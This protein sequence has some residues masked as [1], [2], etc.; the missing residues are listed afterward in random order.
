MRQLVLVIAAVRTNW[1]R[2][3]SIVGSGLGLL[4][5]LLLATSARAQGAAPAPV[6]A[7]AMVSG[8]TNAG[9]A[10]LLPGDIVRLRIWREPDLS[11]DFPVDEKGTVVFPKIGPTQVL[12]MTTDSLKQVLVTTYAQYLRDP[13][14]EVTFLRRVTILGAVKNPGLYPVDPTMTVSDAVALAGGALPTGRPHNFEL[15]RN[16]QRIDVDFNLT[17]PIGH[18]PIRSG[19]EIYVP[20]R[21]W[22]SKNGPLV[23]GASITAVAIVISAFIR[24]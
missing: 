18:T 8:D 12:Q 22:F 20:E 7:G 2:T 16:G 1:M 14:I 23:I 10:T 9:S 11:G 24:Y 6:S 5:V 19:D 21:S 13:A 17:T 4:A 3:G 15:R